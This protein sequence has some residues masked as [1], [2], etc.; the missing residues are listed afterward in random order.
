MAASATNTKQWLNDQSAASGAIVIGN[1]KV[2]ITATQY[3][4]DEQAERALLGAILLIGQ[5][6]T[7]DT[8][9]ALARVGNVTFEDFFY[10]RHG[11]IYLAMHSINKRGSKVDVQSLATELRNAK[12][13]GVDFL[14]QVGGED[15]LLLC[16]QSAKGLNLETYA[17][18]IVHISLRRYLLFNSQRQQTLYSDTGRSLRDLM[19]EAQ[20]AT[21]D[22]NRRLLNMQKKSTF[23][24][25]D[26]VQQ[27]VEQVMQEALN[28]NFVPGISSGIKELDD[29]IL[30]FQPGRGYVLAA[31]SG[32]GKSVVLENFAIS[33]AKSGKRV[34]YIT[35]EMSAQEFTDR[36]ICMLAKINYENYQTRQMSP[37]EIRKLGAAYTIFLDLIGAKMIT[38]VEMTLPTLDEVES[39]LA[40]LSMDPGFDMVI[41][42]YLKADKF[43]IDGDERNQTIEIFKRWESWKKDMFSGAT[44]LTATQINRG[45]TAS[46][47]DY[48][49]DRLYGSTIIQNVS[50]VV[51]FMY[52]E[53][54]AVLEEVNVSPF[55]YVE[56]LIRKGRNVRSKGFI[57]KAILDDDTLAL[58][59]VFAQEPE[60]EP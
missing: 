11:I 34:A 35:L 46:R 43:T 50:D 13:N 15:Y 60:G 40:E 33:A 3:P 5:S 54:K 16:M 39:K 30:Y 18:Q 58:R 27:R 47:D 36:A 52:R 4:A 7:A 55:V 23:A 44:H 19:L 8:R 6:P 1:T 32:W 12:T 45:D 42:D 25:E 26:V 24:I 2:P 14:S 29:A 20:A 51:I 37:D 10:R 49:M 57:P 22:A 59:E 38:I 17:E 48:N 31:P 41:I 53:D 21:R 9:Q 28:P 56:F